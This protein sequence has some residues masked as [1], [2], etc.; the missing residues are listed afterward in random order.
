MPGRLKL[1]PL[2]EQVVVI[3]G[4]TSGIG[5]ATAREAASR[6]AAVFLIARNEAALRTL[7]D[8]IK[9]RGGRAGLAVADVGD[10]AQVRAAAE[11]CRA[12]FGGWDTWINDAGVTIF[13]PIRET[14]L[15]DQRRLFDTNYW[16]VVHGSLAA[17]EH[18][19]MRPVGGA[20]INVGSV[21]GDAPMPVQGVYSAAEHA[22]KGFT[23]ALRMDLMHE[24]APVAVTLIKPSSVDTPYKDHGKNLTDAPVRTPSPVYSAEAVAEAI[25]HCAEHKVREL[26]V[27]GG[28]RALAGFYNAMPSVAEPLFARMMPGLHRDKHATRRRTDD[29]L[30]QPGRDLLEHSNYGRVRRRS[31]FTWAEMHPFT[32]VG[33]ALGL[34]VA[35]G[36]VA[37]AAKVRAERREQRAETRWLKSHAADLGSHAADLGRRLS[38]R[39]Q[40]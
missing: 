30:H 19:R 9:A 34:G 22:V 27:G 35:A 37:L 8:E 16:G 32:I 38:D 5:L 23:N 4:A 24:N 39:A 12:E 10:E 25:L 29:A 3:T 1:K 18:L 31:L 7:V 33:T 28:G 6:G 17:V 40:T 2:H 20:V 26:T 13:G 11:K 15:E 21:L 14:T 36:G